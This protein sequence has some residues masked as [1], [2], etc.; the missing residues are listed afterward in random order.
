MDEYLAEVDTVFIMNTDGVCYAHKK[1]NIAAAHAFMD[2]WKD[3]FEIMYLHAV[4]PDRSHPQQD[5]ARMGSVAALAA[6]RIR[7]LGE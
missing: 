7:T 3:L 5:M 2:K 4:A 6:M 1:E